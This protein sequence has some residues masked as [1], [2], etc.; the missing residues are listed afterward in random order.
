[1][2]VSFLGRPH[3]IRVHLSDAG[4]PIDSDVYYNMFYLRTLEDKGT[5]PYGIAEKEAVRKQP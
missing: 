3:Q 4:F 5:L 2:E 1:M